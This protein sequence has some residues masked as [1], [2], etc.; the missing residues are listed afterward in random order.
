MTKP[1]SRWPIWK[2]AVATGLAV[3]ISAALFV[4]SG[5]LESLGLEEPNDPVQRG[6]LGLPGFVLVLGMGMSILSVIGFIWLGLRIHEA[7]TPPWER[8]K[9]GKRR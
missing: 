6:V 7:R 1:A 9:R 2:V 5:Y 3:V 4:L 8:K